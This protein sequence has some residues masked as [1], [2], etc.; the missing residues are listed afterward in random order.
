M[1]PIQCHCLY[2]ISSWVCCVSFVI[3]LGAIMFY[4]V[5]GG[6]SHISYICTVLPLPC[7]I[8][9]FLKSVLV[10]LLDI[11]KSISHATSFQY[12]LKCSILPLQ[13]PFDPQ[14][15]EICF[16]FFI[17]VFVASVFLQD[18]VRN[19][20]MKPPTWENLGLLFCLTSILWHT[21]YHYIC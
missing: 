19:S 7:M 3:P 10:L 6:E 5:P 21:Q 12:H 17:S 16:W 2:W 9:I 4:S 13:V 1:H 14:N 18:E 20:D 15:Y 8:L 11:R